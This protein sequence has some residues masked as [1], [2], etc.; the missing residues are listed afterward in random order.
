[1]DFSIQFKI[2]TCIKPR[3]YAGC[4]R[5]Y[6]KNLGTTYY[7][8]DL[9]D[10]DSYRI[11]IHT[12]RLDLFDFALRSPPHV[13]HSTSKKPNIGFI[14]SHCLTYILSYRKKLP[15]HARD[16][17]FKRIRILLIAQ[18]IATNN[19]I[20]DDKRRNTR[21][22]TYFRF[23]FKKIILYF[24]LYFPCHCGLPG[25]RLLLIEA[26]VGVR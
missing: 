23:S 10:L 17:Y 12:N 25:P 24:G 19:R 13:V 26:T 15:K 14:V 16:K 18:H 1:M 9:T 5:L 6:N 2:D 11:I 8:I 3:S 21:T 20:K 22:K 7:L 4:N